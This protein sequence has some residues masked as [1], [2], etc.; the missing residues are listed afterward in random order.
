MPCRSAS[1]SAAPAATAASPA[2]LDTTEP[3]RAPT[4]L[5][6]GSPTIHRKSVAAR[7]VAAVTQA[8]W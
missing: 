3:V 7:H 4:W 5:V 8:Q 6:E 2:G 1:A